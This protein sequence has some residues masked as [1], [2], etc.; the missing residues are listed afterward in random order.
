MKKLRRQESQ[1]YFFDIVITRLRGDTIVVLPQIVE[2]VVRVGLS[3]RG[4][5]AVNAAWSAL[6]V[7]T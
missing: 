6:N 3:S 2:Y 7:S 5:W 4:F 1:R